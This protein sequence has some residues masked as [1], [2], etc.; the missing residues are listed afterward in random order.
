MY[1]LSEEPVQLHGC[2]Q[3][4]KVSPY[5]SSFSL[6]PFSIPPASYHFEEPASTSMITFL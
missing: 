3:R 6:F 4:E 5:N 1:S 2:P